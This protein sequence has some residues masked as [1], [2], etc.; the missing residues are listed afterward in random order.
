[1]CGQMFG[2]V[3]VVELFALPLPEDFDPGKGPPRPGFDILASRRH[4]PVRTIEALEAA[5][6][7][8][9]WPGGEP[10]IR[11]AYKQHRAP[12]GC[13]PLLPARLRKRVCSTPSKF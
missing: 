2:A 7:E 13:A 8:Q 6:L 10:S 4:A 1:M 9:P 5:F 11:V 12:E 3:L